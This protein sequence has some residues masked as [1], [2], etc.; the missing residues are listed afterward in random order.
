LKKEVPIMNKPVKR[1]KE[2][3]DDFFNAVLD[4]PN[5]DKKLAS[6]IK[7]LYYEGKLTKTNL[8]NELASLREGKIKDENQIFRY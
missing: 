3:L 8:S 7:K 1:G 2:I 5:V 4:I 6:G